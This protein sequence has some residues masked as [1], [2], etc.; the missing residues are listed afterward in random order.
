[1]SS[2]LS[3]SAKCHWYTRLLLNAIFL[4]RIKT[5]DVAVP[6]RTGCLVLCV[7]QSSSILP[8]ML[9]RSDTGC[10]LCNGRK[11]EEKR[12]LRQSQTRSSCEVAVNSKSQTNTWVS[13]KMKV[14]ILM[15]ENYPGSKFKLLIVLRRFDEIW[16]EV[17][18][19]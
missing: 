7:S 13:G 14:R 19:D 16:R 18:H 4:G 11:A 17:L 1:M 10:L 2:G 9:I 12:K 5:F 15:K 6:F 3:V 8:I